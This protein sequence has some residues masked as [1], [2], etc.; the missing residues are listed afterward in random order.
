MKV[1][2]AVGIGQGFDMASLAQWSDS[3]KYLLLDYRGPVR[4]GT[5][6]RFNW[7]ILEEYKHDVPFILSGGIGTGD[8][9]D[10]ARV[11]NPS[12]AGIDLNS[13]FE[14]SPGIKDID[15]LGDFINEYRNFQINRS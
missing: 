9:A 10:L 13:R 3:C 15:V 1:I 14:S 5:G 12:F 6:E 11:K 4:G 2:K 7:E 8:V